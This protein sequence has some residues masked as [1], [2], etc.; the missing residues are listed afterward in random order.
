MYMASSCYKAYFMSISKIRVIDI[1]GQQ[2]DRWRSS[3][4]YDE[5]EQK[6]ASQWKNLVWP[7]ISDSS[8]NVTLELACGHGRNSEFLLGLAERL[9]LVDVNVENITFC[10]SRFT[11][12][13]GKIDY[14]VNNGTEFADVADSSVDFIYCFDSMVH[15]HSDVVRSY[16]SDIRR[17]L[18]LNG[19]AFLHHSNSTANPGGLDI[20]KHIQGRNYMSQSMF[21]HYSILEGL[22]VIKSRVLD[23]GGTKDLD[24]F[25]LVQ[26]FR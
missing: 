14:I 11:G 26:K 20:R 6:F 15:F 10:K 24:C 5:A 2:A 13:D 25:S 16:L 23:W 9:I 1:A 22:E 8:F 4:Y 17:C 21:S 18:K 12:R 3:P 7:F 19:R